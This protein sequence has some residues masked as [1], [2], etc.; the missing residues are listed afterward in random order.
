MRLTLH[1]TDLRVG[2]T[3]GQLY[4]D[5]SRFCSTLEDTNRDEDRDGRFGGG[6]EKVYGE[7]CIPFGEYRVR[8]SMSPKFKRELPEV[9]D[10]P[11]FSGIRIHR[12]N[13]PKDTLGCI[14]V[15]ERVEDGYLYNSTPYETRLTQLLKDAQERG[16]E[17]ELTIR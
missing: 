5:G 16:E 10:V 2:Y 4:V 6:E 7:T 13:T 1:R 14:L 9:L 3:A 15:G 8:V 17:I 12:G 11:H